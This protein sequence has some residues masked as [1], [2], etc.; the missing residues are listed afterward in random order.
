MVINMGNLC[1]KELHVPARSS[2]VT[3]STSSFFMPFEAENNYELSYC[4]A[5]GEGESIKVLLSYLMID[6]KETLLPPC[7][8]RLC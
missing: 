8:S 2:I 7:T 5:T 4:P 1:G 6:Y 3:D